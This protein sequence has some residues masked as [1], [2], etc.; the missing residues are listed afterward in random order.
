MG[1]GGDAGLS[2]RVTERQRRF[3]EAYLETGSA[4][5]AA[6]R[7]GYPAGRAARVLKS[8]GVRACLAAMDAAR[9]DGGV[10][11]ARE[12]L[13]YLTGVMRG[14]GDEARQGASSPRMKAAE[15]LGK[16]L[17]VFNEVA[18]DVK[19]PVILDD[20]P[21][22]GGGEPPAGELPPGGG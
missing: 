17:G 12:V 3:A 15:L 5:E 7:A 14:E 20:V 19:P 13:E 2:L 8:P 6:R 10:A 22:P 21:R 1:R 16:R 4:A 18:G 11:S 9:E